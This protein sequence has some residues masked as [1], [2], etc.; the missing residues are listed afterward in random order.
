MLLKYIAIAG[1]WIFG[2]WYLITGGAWL[3]AH[4]IGRGAAHHEV[5]AGAIA[6]QHALTE[7]HFMDPFA[8]VNVPVRRCSIA[9]SSHS[10]ARH[11]NACARRCSNLL[12]SPSAVREM[13]MGHFEFGL[14]C[15]LGLV[16]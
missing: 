9:Y 13:D 5:T 1:R 12:V 8:R 4:A 6:F 7:S 10:A 3:L 14:V 16:L 2:L 15:R 11:H